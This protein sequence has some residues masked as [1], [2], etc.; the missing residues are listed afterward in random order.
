MLASCA[1][2]ISRQTAEF[3]AAANLLSPRSSADAMLAASA[4][5]A[6]TTDAE[7]VSISLEAWLAPL[8]SS[9]EDTVDPP[10][11]PVD[12]SVHP[13]ASGLHVDA[14]S[15]PALH[16]TASVSASQLV[17]EAD[18]SQAAQRASG[19]GIQSSDSAGEVPVSL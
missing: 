1:K 15:V 13:A 9:S 17:L 5:H 3:A 14:V 16:A 12:S 11:V 7:G 18:V 8:A 2:Y 10:V 19:D 6:S 4:A